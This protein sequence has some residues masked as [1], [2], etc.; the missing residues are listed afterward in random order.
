MSNDVEHLFSKAAVF[1]WDFH[2]GR[3]QNIGLVAELP[4]TIWYTA[5]ENAEALV[6]DVAVQRATRRL[7]INS[8]PPAYRGLAKT[9]VALYPNTLDVVGVFG[10]VKHKDLLVG[11]SAIVALAYAH[12]GF[13]LRYDGETLWYLIDERR[14]I[15][16]ESCAYQKSLIEFEFVCQG[17]ELER[18]LLSPAELIGVKPSAIS[19]VSVD[20]ETYTIALFP[21]IDVEAKKG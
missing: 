6:C 12:G 10:G 17:Y 14:V 4:E 18:R 9:V 1:V 21:K 2:E 15:Q 13:G 5:E 20:G 11:W 7:I 19:V 3:L 8:Y 16:V